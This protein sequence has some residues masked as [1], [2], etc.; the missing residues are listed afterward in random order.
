MG[1]RL[2]TPGAVGF[3]L[4]STL[5]LLWFFVFHTK[6]SR[7]DNIFFQVNLDDCFFETPHNLLFFLSRATTNLTKN[8]ILLLEQTFLCF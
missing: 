1:D 5:A 3:F 6:E 8:F 2:G 7:P 4:F